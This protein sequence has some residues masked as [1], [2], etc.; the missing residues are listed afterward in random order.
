M[1]T[2]LPRSGWLIG[3]LVVGLWLAGGAAAAHGQSALDGFDPNAN[4]LVRVVV[5]QSDGKILIGG[6]FT[7]LSPN[8]GVAVT[9]K[10]RAPT[11]AERITQRRETWPVYRLR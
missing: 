11:Q 7:T 6:D 4:G 5:V 10:L 9:R 3:F 1:K 8:G 2:I